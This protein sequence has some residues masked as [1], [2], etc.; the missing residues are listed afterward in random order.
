MDKDFAAQQ[1]KPVND[2]IAG[3]IESS[4]NR[5]LNDNNA[6]FTTGTRLGETQVEKIQEGMESMKSN[7]VN[8]KRAQ[9]DIEK[10]LV[11]LEKL[12]DKVRENG[13]Y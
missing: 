8:I 3:Q 12:K 2:E 11:D 4:I 13:S 1:I 5:L 10:I 6:V 9:Q 7:T